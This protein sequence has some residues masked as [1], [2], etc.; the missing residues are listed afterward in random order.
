MAKRTC[1]DCF[2]CAACSMW[3]EMSKANA[4]KCAQ[5]EP[6]RYASLAD[7][8]EMHQM[9][10]KISVKISDVDY[11][12]RKITLLINEKAGK[13]ILPLTETEKGRQEVKW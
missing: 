13:N 9:A 5:F 7:L 8:N 2:H 1:E 4:A 6:M 12:L 10:T 11:Y 3:G